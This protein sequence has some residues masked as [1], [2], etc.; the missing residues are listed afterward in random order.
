MPTLFTC[1]VAAATATARALFC[2]VLSKQFYF[3]IIPASAD[4]RIIYVEICKN[5]CKPPLLPNRKCIIKFEGLFHIIFRQLGTQL[6]FWALT[7]QPLDH[8]TMGIG[9]E[10]QIWPSAIARSGSTIVQMFVGNTYQS[11]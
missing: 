7:S 8:W 2:Y 6:T 10:Q 11:S 9:N 5:Q 4:V 3:C 1:S